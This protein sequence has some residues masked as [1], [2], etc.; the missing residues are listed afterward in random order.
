[1]S[2]AKLLLDTNIVIGLLK[3]YEPA[4]QLVNS[5]G[6]HLAQA[7]VSQITR[8]ELLGYPGITPVE[9][10]AI[11]ILLQ[12]T[13][14][15][16]IDQDVEAQTIALRRKHNIKLPDAIIAATALAKNLRLITLDKALLETCA[17]G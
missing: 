9:E 12:A 14:C 16:V 7:A 2:G 11:Q 13:T 8:M 6:L 4:V 3:G 15:I 5:T 17:S 1:M 10:H